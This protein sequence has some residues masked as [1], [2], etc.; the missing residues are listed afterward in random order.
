LSER[1]DID[2]T[3]VAYV[4]LS[5]GATHCVPLIALEDRVKVAAAGRRIHLI[6]NCHRKPT[7]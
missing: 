2:T 1:Q 3:R 7:R 6:A 4:G 5:F